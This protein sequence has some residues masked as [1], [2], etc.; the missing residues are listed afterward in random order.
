MLLMKSGIAFPGIDDGTELP[1]P[2]SWRSLSKGRVNGAEAAITSR[3][4]TGDAVDRG[5]P[6]DRHQHYFS[7]RAP[8][9]SRSRHGSVVQGGLDVR[10]GA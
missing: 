1:D 6:P 4:L 5:V 2:C 8:G 9:M 3:E 7:C 10:G